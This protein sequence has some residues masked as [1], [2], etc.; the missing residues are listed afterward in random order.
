MVESEGVIKQVDALGHPDPDRYAAGAWPAALLARMAYW[1]RR[2]HRHG[3]LLDL[4]CAEGGLLDLLGTGGIGLDMNSERLRLAA[5][6]GIRACLGDG[7]MLPFPDDCFDTVI[8]MEVLEHVPDMSAVMAEV[9]RVLRPGG[10]WVLSVPN[11][12]LRS[13]YE[14]WHERRPYYCDS[15]EHYREFTAV[16]IPWFEHRFIHASDMGRMFFDAGFKIY[17]KDGVRYLFPQWFSRVGGLQQCIESPEMDR[18]W[19][20]MPWIRTFPYWQIMV[21]EKVGA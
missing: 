20:R 4:G 8:S 10:R 12:T 15:G 1:V 5:E 9:H 3:H 19:S 13:W 16:D 6:K 21:F 18:V 17:S 7:G 14:M 11:V 2:V